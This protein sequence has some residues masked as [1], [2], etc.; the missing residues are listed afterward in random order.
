MSENFSRRLPGETAVDYFC[1]SEVIVAPFIDATVAACLTGWRVVFVIQI[2]FFEPSDPVTS[3]VNASNV[4]A[5]TVTCSRLEG[6]GSA[7]EGL[8]F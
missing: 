8:A 7:Q 5:G 1:S 3:I 6:F 4:P 2:V